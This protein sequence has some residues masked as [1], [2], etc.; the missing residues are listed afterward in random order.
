M[1]TQF[2][3][4]IILGAGFT[5][6]ILALCLANRGIDVCLVDR[7]KTFKSIID[8]RTTA[9]SKGS[10][11]ILEEIGAWKELKKDAQKIEKIIVS[12]GISENHLSLI[13]V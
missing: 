5:G 9:I 6:K 4:L 12:E 3:D 11:L 8:K 7:N 2:Y 10:T 13:Q 1:K